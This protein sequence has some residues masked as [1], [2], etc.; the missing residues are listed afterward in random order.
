MKKL[1]CVLAAISMFLSQGAYAQGSQNP[2]NR[3]YTITTPGQSP[4]FVNPN[5]FGGGYP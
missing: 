3:G 5:P 4:T 2:Y 1:A